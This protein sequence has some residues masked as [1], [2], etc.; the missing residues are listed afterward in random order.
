M[1]FFSDMRRDYLTRPF[2]LSR[3]LWFTV[4]GIF[5]LGLAVS[6]YNALVDGPDLNGS[7][8]WPLFFALAGATWGAWASREPVPAQAERER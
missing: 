6:I 3:T 2:P 7:L 8:V 1:P 4:G 5:A